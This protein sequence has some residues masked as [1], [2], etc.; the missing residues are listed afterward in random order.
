MQPLQFAMRSWSFFLL[1]VFIDN[2]LN[3]YIVKEMRVK[4]TLPKSVCKD[5]AFSLKKQICG[6]LSWLNRTKGVFLWRK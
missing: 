2:I 6:M 3:N 4:G 1:C 5:T